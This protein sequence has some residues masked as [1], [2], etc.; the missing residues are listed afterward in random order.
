MRI[1]EERTRAPFAPDS[2]AVVTGAGRGIGRAIAEVL[3]EEGPHIAVWDID[4]DTAR[5][6]AQLITAR[7]GSA[8]AHQ[9]DIT[10]DD[11]IDRGWKETAAI[12][13]CRYLVNNA[14]IPSTL[15]LT[16]AEGLAGTIGGLVAVTEGWLAA[17]GEEAA[18]VVNIS[19]IAGNDVGGGFINAYY[20]V[21]KGA[22]AAYTRHL[23]V[24]EHGRPRAN[25]VAPGFTLTPR[26]APLLDKPGT[27]FQEWVQRG[28][29][30][31][32]GLPHE[33]A[34]VV[35]FLLSERASF[36]N[37]EYIRVDGAF[38]LAD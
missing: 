26:S 21:G 33:I 8:S 36:V 27:S 3:A 19:S 25:T 32:P 17:V 29:M 24:R 13:P 10:H 31:R 37:G 15:P 7:G 35:T 18:S 20:P 22:I 16:M 23:A 1:N 11:E 12:G 38:V 14:G 34:E 2:V 30:K 5:D 9:V 28:P 6:A 4:G